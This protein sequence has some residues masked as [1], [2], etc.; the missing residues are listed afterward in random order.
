MKSLDRFDERV[1][2]RFFD[3]VFPD[4]RQLTREQ[5][6]EDLSRAGIDLGPA[7]KAI[8]QA[9][10]H[11]REAHDA[12]AAL[13]TAKRDRPSVL[14]RLAG[15]AAPPSPA[16]R[17]RLSQMIAER[18]SG[19]LQQVYARKLESAASDD[20]LR[21]LLEDLSRLEVFSEDS[22]DAES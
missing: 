17:E 22:D 3:F 21:S 10:K 7:L 6:Q 11:A 20:D 1:W 14:Q 15:I 16:I 4:E 12:R 13:E 8:G 18:F 2:R 5:V 9:L 19:P